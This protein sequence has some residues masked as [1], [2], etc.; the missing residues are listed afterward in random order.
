M[1]VEIETE[2]RHE[3]T[4]CEYEDTKKINLKIHTLKSYKSQSEEKKRSE[5][6]V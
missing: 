2:D 5:V 3:C 1:K 6:P 4:P